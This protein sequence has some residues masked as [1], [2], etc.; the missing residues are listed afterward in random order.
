M[1]YACFQT[2]ADATG[3]N[4]CDRLD[5]SH[6][7]D[8]GS[9]V[10]N[11]LAVTADAQDA[12]SYYVMAVRGK[13]WYDNGKAIEVKQS[14]LRKDAY[15]LVTFF[16]PGSDGVEDDRK[17]SWMYNATTAPDQGRSYAAPPSDKPYDHPAFPGVIMCE[18]SVG[19]ES[20]VGMGELLA[21]HM[22]GYFDGEIEVIDG[23]YGLG[24]KTVRKFRLEGD[25]TIK[26]MTAYLMDE[27]QP[28]GS[29]LP[30]RVSNM[31]DGEG[32]VFILKCF[33]NECDGV[34]ADWSIDDSEL[35]LPQGCSAPEAV[36]RASPA[37]ELFTGTNPFPPGAIGDPNSESSRKLFANIMDDR[38]RVADGTVSAESRRSLLS[39]EHHLGRDLA[40]LA[41][42]GELEADAVLTEDGIRFELP[43][44][45]QA[46]SKVLTA[47]L[48][49]LAVYGRHS[50]G[51]HLLGAASKFKNLWNAAGSSG[52]QIQLSANDRPG[53]CQSIYLQGIPM[54][55]VTM[56]LGFNPEKPGE[57][58]LL[59][60]E[61]EVQFG[62]ISVSL[63]FTIDV[64]KTNGFS[65]NFEIAGTVSFS[66]GVYG[67]GIPFAEGSIVGGQQVKDSHPCMQKGICNG[68]TGVAVVGYAGLVA[69]VNV[70]AVWGTLYYLVYPSQDIDSR[71]HYLLKGD[72]N[73]GINVG[74]FSV[75]AQVF[76]NADNPVLWW[77]DDNGNS[78]TY[79]G[80]KLNLGDRCGWN[81]NRACFTGVCC[82]CYYG[83]GVGS[84]GESTRKGD[85]CDTHESWWGYCEGEFSK[86]QGG[87][88]SC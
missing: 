2:G 16:D 59:A 10:Y 22:D 11:N 27:Q 4:R 36:L 34:D 12:Q 29:Y 46:D 55:P 81:D 43:N 64:D 79:S 42:M 56:L 53:N 6:A 45:V 5:L 65:G 85:I 69:N 67:V 35:A 75:G 70:V 68:N 9:A 50:D 40:A 86:A 37:P 15:E 21:Q 87:N 7:D 71:Y 49:D 19:E 82:G 26:Y 33:D 20:E 73:V 3:A 1:F 63:S 28:D 32:T 57:Y 58:C 24:G 39:A 74:F 23:S 14:V 62:L 60:V 88:P 51:R 76:N 30:R 38:R 78:D 25:E 48:E 72:V 80:K 41:G 47:P 13:M 83:M 31:L 77:E 84:D 52:A 61:G 8:P 18:E 44:P 54:G 17:G 66:V